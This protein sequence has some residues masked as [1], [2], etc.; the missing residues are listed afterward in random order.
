MHCIYIGEGGGPGFVIWEDGAC[1]EWP[2]KKD[3]KGAFHAVEVDVLLGAREGK[4]LAE[5]T[6]AIAWCSD[7]NV[8]T[9]KSL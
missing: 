7:G 5:T 8:F 4:G 2:W 1:E 3:G 6:N 9:L